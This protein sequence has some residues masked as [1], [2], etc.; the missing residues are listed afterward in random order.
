MELANVSFVRGASGWVMTSWGWRGEEESLFSGKMEEDL[1]HRGW[2]MMPSGGEVV[3][4]WI[5]FYISYLYT[6]SFRLSFILPL[7]ITP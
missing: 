2:R 5:S 6:Y 1:L 7:L 3:L 4:S